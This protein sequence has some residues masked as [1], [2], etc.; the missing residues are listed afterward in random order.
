VVLEK[1]GVKI[2]LEKKKAKEKKK[3]ISWTEE[4][5]QS[6]KCFLYQFTV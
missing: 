4:I 5:I 3:S 1:H 2:H 6:L